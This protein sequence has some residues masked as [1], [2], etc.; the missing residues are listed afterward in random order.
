MSNTS[1]SPRKLAKERLLTL[2]R[3][4]RKLQR[5]KESWEV[6][7]DL[8]TLWEMGDH[9]DL[10]AFTLY[11]LALIME[12]KGWYDLEE[13]KLVLENVAES[14]SAMAQCYLGRFYLEG[15]PDHP[16]DP[17]F[18]RYWIQQA[19]AQGYRQALDYLDERWK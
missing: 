3:I 9:G 17:I 18:G 19:A 8:Q 16:V 10:D 13:G 14:G 15:R 12:D 4:T 11:G 7:D 6:E 2:A 5:A 1:P